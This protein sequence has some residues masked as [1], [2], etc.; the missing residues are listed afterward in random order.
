MKTCIQLEFITVPDF[1]NN[2]FS[3]DMK[4]PSEFLATVSLEQSSSEQK[5]I[6][7]TVYN[8]VHFKKRLQ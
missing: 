1:L 2:Y 5:C 3:Q 7:K 6:F 4:N 8:Y